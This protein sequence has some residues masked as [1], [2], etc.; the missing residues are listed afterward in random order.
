MPCKQES[1]LMEYKILLK[2]HVHT[3]DKCPWRNDQDIAIPW[4]FH[5]FQVACFYCRNCWSLGQAQPPCKE[6]CKSAIVRHCKLKH[7][8]KSSKI[9]SSSEEHEI[10]HCSHPSERGQT[11]S[12]CTW[13]PCL[14]FASSRASS[15]EEDWLWKGRLR[16][17]SGQSHQPVMKIC[18]NLPI[19]CILEINQ[20]HE[21]NILYLPEEGQSERERERESKYLS[22][23]LRYC[24]SDGFK[25]RLPIYI[26]LSL[27]SIFSQA[28]RWCIGTEPV[29]IAPSF[30]WLL[31]CTVDC[32]NPTLNFTTA[33]S[34]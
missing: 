20:F 34:S 10:E 12:I 1:L 13:T 22:F 8:M 21:G 33:G 6:E 3:K 28:P 27:T 29:R 17:S 25:S 26:P 24:R 23:C 11:I 31:G 5:E 14:A 15:L 9:R 30:R 19:T 16:Y 18:R 7:W 2:I 4:R 32:R